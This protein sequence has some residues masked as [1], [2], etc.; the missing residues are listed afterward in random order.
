M[1]FFFFKVKICLKKNVRIEFI[2][3]AV[4][5]KPPTNQIWRQILLCTSFC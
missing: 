3:L 4:I 1:D 2:K 5:K